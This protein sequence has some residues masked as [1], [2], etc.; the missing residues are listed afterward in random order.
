MGNGRLGA[1]SDG[2][3]T[4]II[5]IATPPVLLP[6]WIAGWSYVLVALIW[7][8]PDRRIEHALCNQKT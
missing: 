6:Q 2:V 7:L 5:T 8:V 1:F 4:L 3:L